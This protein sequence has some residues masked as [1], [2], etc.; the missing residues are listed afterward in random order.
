MDSCFHETF[1]EKCN[2]WVRT[3]KYLRTYSFDSQLL[4]KFYEFSPSTDFQQKFWKI[5]WS[6]TKSHLYMIIVFTKCFWSE[7]KF[8]NSYNIMWKNE[9]F[10]LTEKIFR[11][12]NSLMISLVKMLLS[13][14]FCQRSVRENIRNFHTAVVVCSH[15]KN[16]SWNQLFSKTSLK[17][18]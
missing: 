8:L 7:S 5:N 6:S 13:W 4:L 12:I 2:S 14:N 3:F 9:K 18:V 10:A 11:Q 1:L 16:I 15:R 17:T